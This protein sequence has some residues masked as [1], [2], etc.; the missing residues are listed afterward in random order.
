MDT[1][2][3]IELMHTASLVFDD[4]PC[5]DDAGERRGVSC[6]HREYGEAVAILSAL[7]LIN[8]AY[9]LAWRA[10]RGAPIKTSDAAANL[11]SCCLG[12]NGLISGQTRD[13]V[14]PS[15]SW[16][17]KQTRA[18][19]MQK[20]VPLIRL[21][22]VFPALLGGAS[23]RELQLLNRLATFWGMAYQIGDD[24]KD[25]LFTSGQS[26]KTANRDHEMGRP[27]MVLANGSRAAMAMTG[28]FLARANATI[29]QLPGEPSSWTFLRRRH[30]TF[31]AEATKHAAV[32]A[33]HA[34]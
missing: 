11:F 17:E 7:A 29:A 25:V 2:L 22:L 13:L 18:V 21:A 3:S 1:A 31:L 12:V 4:L 10:M 28:R 26:G 27:N 32:T 19:A 6:V 9:L 5:M 24:I 8:Q 23:R 30:V 15:G 34:S 33:S 20:T 14:G 16:N